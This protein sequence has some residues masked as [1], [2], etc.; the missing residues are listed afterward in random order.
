MDNN[1]ELLDNIRKYE[2][3]KARGESLYLDVDSLIDIAEHYYSEKHLAKALEVIDYAIDLFPGSTLPLCFKARQALNEKNIEKAEAYAAQVEDRTD[4]EYQYLMV[5][6]LLCKGQIEHADMLMEEIY[7]NAADSEKDEC[8]L[9][10]AKVFF[11]YEYDE[12]CQK[13]LNKCADKDSVGYMELKSRYAISKGKF[14]QGEKFLDKLLDQD[15][16][17]ATYW[18]QMASAQFLS[19]NIAKSLES[20]DYALAID[21]NNVDAIIHKANCLCSLENYDEAIKYYLRYSEL[22]PES[23]LGD[24]F[25]GIC[26]SNRD[27]YQEAIPHLQKAIEKCSPSSDNLLPI[28][29]ELAYCYSAT[30]NLPEALNAI[31]M[32]SMQ[33]ESDAAEIRCMRSIC[34]IMNGK[35]L[36]A[37]EMFKQALAIADSDQLLQICIDFSAASI[38]SQHPDLA[39]F[40]LHK[41][42][43]EEGNEQLDDGWGYY[44]LA[45]L[46]LNKPAEYYTALSNVCQRNPEE[47]K[48][49]LGSLFPDGTPVE[50]YINYSN[51]FFK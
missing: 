8:A 46:Q 27:K 50:D 3:A 13:W 44:A 30:K 26:Y 36:E 38:D 6:I 5:E 31:D 51:N 9:E 32:A 41:L 18:T 45:C 39:Y 20:C 49:V 22:V 24:M 34:Y 2:D 47:A 10:I 11:D 40:I 43:Y 4:I 1:S 21:S 29:K 14:T 48:Q 15:P 16:F 23:E 33:P 37:F 12:K 17:S 19:N 42:Y 7:D 25:L 28:Y 35:D